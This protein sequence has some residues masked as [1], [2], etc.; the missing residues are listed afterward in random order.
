MVSKGKVRITRNGKTERVK[1]PHTLIRPGHEAIFMR[2]N[3]LI[4]IEV[5]AAALRRGPAREAVTLYN[6][7]ESPP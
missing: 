4:H 5:L 6:I 7:L 3:E 2:G 1:K